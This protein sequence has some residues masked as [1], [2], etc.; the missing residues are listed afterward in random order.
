MGGHGVRAVN[1]HRDELLAGVGSME[2]RVWTAGSLELLCVDSQGT[3]L[4]ADADQYRGNNPMHR[5]VNPTF[6][7][8]A[9][10]FGSILDTYTKQLRSSR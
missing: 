8:T 2:H 1:V 10:D 4:A 6:W 3:Q 5:R 7:L 9:G